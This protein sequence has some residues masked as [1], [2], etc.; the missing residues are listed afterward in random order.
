MRPRYTLALLLMAIPVA[1]CSATDRWFE[2]IVATSPDGQWKV[3]ARS[4]D[5]R[6]AGYHPWQDDLVYSAFKGQE[7]V[8]VWTRDQS[9]PKP[10]EGS[11]VRVVVAGS[12][13]CPC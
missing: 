12:A 10:P 9:R 3:E 1:L 13:T 11:P 8:P 6:G 5:N 4:P 7:G 2:D